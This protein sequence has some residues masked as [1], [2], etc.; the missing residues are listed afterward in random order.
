MEAQRERIILTGDVPSPLNP[1]SGC[2]FHTRCP[3]AIDVC[4]EEDPEMREIE[5]GHFARCHRV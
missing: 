3:I 4:R 2:N 1:P 5:P